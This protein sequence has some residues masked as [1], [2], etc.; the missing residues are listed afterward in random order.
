MNEVRPR[1]ENGGICVLWCVLHIVM[2]T[3][4]VSMCSMIE[5]LSCWYIHGFV[6]GTHSYLNLPINLILES[7][8]LAFS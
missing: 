4:E 6:D 5:P 3:L 8:R 7:K 1:K 2:L